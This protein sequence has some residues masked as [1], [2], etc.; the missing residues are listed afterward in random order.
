MVNDEFI[1]YGKSLDFE[2]RVK[3]Y[4]KDNF[5]HVKVEAI[6]DCDHLSEKELRS[7]EN[8]IGRRVKNYRQVNPGR[9]HK[10]LL[11]WCKNLEE[12]DLKKI[13]REEYEKFNAKTII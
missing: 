11:E 2:L 8:E 6:I 9:A 12:E 4:H 10:S 3:N 7:L 13:I 1:K 5:G